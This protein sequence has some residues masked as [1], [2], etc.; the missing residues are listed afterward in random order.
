MIVDIQGKMGGSRTATPGSNEVKFA[1]TAST[2]IDDFQMPMEMDFGFPYNMGGQE[3]AYFVP[4]GQ[5][6]G[7]DYATAGLNWDSLDWNSMSTQ[8]W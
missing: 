5:V 8:G 2:N 1:N 4:D 3:I 7:S 6:A